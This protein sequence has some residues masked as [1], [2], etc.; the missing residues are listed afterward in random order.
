MN[1]K[2][3]SFVQL[4]SAVDKN[5]LAELEKHGGESLNPGEGTLHTSHSTYTLPPHICF[6]VEL[7]K[8]HSCSSS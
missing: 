1:S 3:L 2:F 4:H 7:E 5:G 8:G 6:H